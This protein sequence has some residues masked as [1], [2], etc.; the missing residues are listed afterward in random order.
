MKAQKR[1]QSWLKKITGYYS[2][3]LKAFI[4]KPVNSSLWILEEWIKPNKIDFWFL[5]KFDFSLWHTTLWNNIRVNRT[6]PAVCRCNRVDRAFVLLHNQ[7][8]SKMFL[9]ELKKSARTPPIVSCFSCD[10]QSSSASSQYTMGFFWMHLLQLK[11]AC[12]PAS[13]FPLDPPVF[14]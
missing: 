5:R 4:V 1:H 6:F 10:V 14:P 8:F 7:D 2:Q 11:Q 3:K 13:E 9:E 12:D